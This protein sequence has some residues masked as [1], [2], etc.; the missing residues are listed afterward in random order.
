[1][2]LWIAGQDRTAEFQAAVER[3][4]ERMAARGACVFFPE[5]ISALRLRRAQHEADYLVL[6]SELVRRRHHIDTLGFRIPRRPGPIGALGAALRRVLWRVLRY[7]HDRMAYRQNLVNSHLFALVEQQGAE[8]RALR[9][10][11]AALEAARSAPDS[12]P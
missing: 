5:D 10:R 12:V 2:K 4:T 9:A 11:V 3:E 1:M 6:F 8:L 7:Q